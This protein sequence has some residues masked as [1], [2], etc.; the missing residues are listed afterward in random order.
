MFM[1]V[2][3][4]HSVKTHFQFTWRN[5]VFFILYTSE[6]HYFCLVFLELLVSIQ[7][8]TRDSRLSVK[9][10]CIYDSIAGHSHSVTIHSRMFVFMGAL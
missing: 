1:G 10:P 3:C 5:A 8:F 4:N 6:K 2:L 9:I 7:L